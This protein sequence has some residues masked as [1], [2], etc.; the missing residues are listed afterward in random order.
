MKDGKGR[1][2]SEAKAGQREHLEETRASVW[3]L[4]THMPTPQS[5]DQRSP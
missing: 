1:G 3:A 4:Y 2:E 5:K